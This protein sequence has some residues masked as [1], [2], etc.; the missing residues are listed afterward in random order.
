MA[1]HYNQ[2]VFIPKNPHKYIGT[3]PINWRSSWELTFMNLCDT[4]P[5]ILQWASE[6]IKIPYKNPL[7]G[8]ISV[9]IPDFIIIYMDKNGKKLGDLVEIKPLNQT[10]DE[11]AYGKRNKDAVLVNT[12]KWEA[13]QQWC[14][15]NGLHFRVLTEH[16]L[17]KNARTRTPRKNRTKPRL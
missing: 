15:R 1:K 2:G 11:M 9:Y 17:Y 7:T 16:D 6:S 12:A 4:H 13:A 8:R 14:K 5:N 3:Y 10:V